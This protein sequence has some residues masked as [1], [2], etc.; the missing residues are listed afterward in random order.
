M[1][2]AF[3]TLAT[4]VFFVSIATSVAVSV[5]TLRTPA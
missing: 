5:A 2:T 1:I 3:F 4:V